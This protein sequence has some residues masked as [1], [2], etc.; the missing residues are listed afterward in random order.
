MLMKEKIPEAE[1][2]SIERIQKIAIFDNIKFAND[3]HKIRFMELA[4]D[5]ENHFL[6]LAIDGIVYKYDLVTKDVLFQFKTQAFKAMK[7][8]DSENNLM[9]A[10]QQQIKLWKF[11]NHLH[12]DHPE[13]ITC[14]QVPLKVEN[15][16]LN[17]YQTDSHIVIVCKNELI[18]YDQA[19]EP[20]FD[21]RI[22]LTD[23]ILSLEFSHTNQ[24]FY[25]GTDKANIFTFSIENQQLM[26]SAIE[27][28]IG[29][30][31]VELMH[32]I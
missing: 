32:R 20:V 8:F 9:A 30:F 12:N 3:L 16:F 25:V 19:L 26:G 4:S 18:V 17:R 6:I 28:E 14:L 7:L 15:A 23:S 29:Q 10:D 13:L 22:P 1:L 2:Q 31:G 5:I 24:G 27:I 21:D 11:N